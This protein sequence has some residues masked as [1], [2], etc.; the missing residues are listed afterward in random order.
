[1]SKITIIPKPYFDIYIDIFNLIQE[2]KVSHEKGHR[3]TD[4]YY[5]LEFLRL[6]RNANDIK[7]DN[8]KFE[9]WTKLHREI[10]LYIDI[11][12]FSTFESYDI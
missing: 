1:M 5:R 9:Q 11:E 6:C 3:K 10:N 8:Y 2:L 7:I 12:M 4:N